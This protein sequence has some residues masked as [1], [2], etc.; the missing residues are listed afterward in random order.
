MFYL[1][2]S[3]AETGKTVMAKECFEKVKKNE[4]QPQIKDAA[5][6]Y[7]KQLSVNN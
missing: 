5:E 2:I 7:L 1:G 4:T 3:Y 6:Q